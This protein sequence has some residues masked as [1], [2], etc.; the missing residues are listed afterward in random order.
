MGCVALPVWALLGGD[1]DRAA[2]WAPLMAL[3][4]TALGLAFVL[5]DRDRHRVVIEEV[6]H[7]WRRPWMAPPLD[8]MVERPELGDRLVAALTAPLPSEVGLTT[9]LAGAG[10]FG[11][12]RL[13]TWV[14]HRPEIQRRYPGGLLWATVGQEVRGADLAE[15][16][17]DLVFALCGE[18]PNI[19]DPYTAGAELGRVLDE[20]K[21]VLL[22]VDDVW[23]ETQLRPFRFGGRGCTRLVTTRVPHLLPASGVRIAVDAMS[24]DQARRLVADG[25]TELP[26]GAD[27]RL[28]RLAGRWPVLLNLV[29]GVLRQRVARGQTAEHAAA[30]I[31][32][33]LVTDG[34]MAFDPARPADRGWAVAATVEASMI[35]LDAGDRERYLDLAI[36]PEDIDIPVDVLRL[37]WP[38]RGVDGLCDELVGLGLAADY[39]LDQPGPRLVL[40]DVMRAYLRTGRNATEHAAVHLRLL[41]AA[42]GLLPAHDD[43]HDDH[44]GLAWWLLPAEAGYLWRYVPHHLHQADRTD[45]LTRLV[46]D[47]RW[48]EA[49]TCRFGSVVTAEADVEL[50]NTPPAVALRRALR[51]IAPL[52]GPIEPPT[53][54]G[55]TLASR[56]YGVPE[57]QA[58][59]D[60]YRATLFRPRLEPAWPPPDGPDSIRSSRA[61]HAGVVTSCA[62]SPD[63]TLLATASTDGT[64]RLWQVADGSARAVLIGHT[65]GVWDCAFSPNGALLATAGEDRTVRLWQVATGEELD[66][67]TGHTDWVTSCTFSPDGGLLATTSVDETT[68]LWHPADATARAVL[69]GHGNPVRSCAFRPDGTLL[70]TAGEDGTA[71]LWHVATGMEVGVLSGH[72]SAGGIWACAFSPDG[73]LLAT[74]GDDRTARLWHVATGIQRALL[75]GHSSRVNACAFSPDGTTLATAS[76]G[77]V[78]LWHTANATVQTVLTG[79]NAR[80]LGCAFSP[81]G[82]VLATAG[83][84]GIAQLWQIADGSTRAVLTSLDAKVSSCAFSPDGTLL[85]TTG[86]DRIVRLRQVSDGHERQVMIGHSRRVNRCAFSSDG[87]LLATVS[88]DGTTRIWKIPHGAVHAV[89]TGHSGWVRS[90]AFSPDGALLATGGTDGK[91]LLWQVAD[92]TQRA[93]LIGHT[94]RVQSCAFSPDGSLLAT[95]S[96]DRSIRLWQLPDGGTHAVLTGHADGVNDCAFSSDG[97][98]LATASDDRTLRLWRLSDGTARAPLTGHTSWV[99]RCAFSPDG[100]LLAGTSNDGTVRLW[101]VGSGRCHCALRVAAPV[102]GIAWHPAGTLLCTVGGAGVY[103]LTYLP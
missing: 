35:L 24:G 21:A 87:S 67:L 81:D 5:A 65:S 96:S 18:R 23:E 14:C 26:I 52:L 75:T 39:R 73:A 72:A 61:Y 89:L 19:S 40:H 37:L 100:T 11:K 15:R 41:D 102:T 90:C 93:V 64:A 8:R 94:D 20:R 80:V 78:R 91:V 85:A 68:R 103:M 44:A 54:L 1:L 25:V 2:R 36:F 31:I 95:A 6:D 49:K 56:L 42:A 22:V 46:C 55:A 29:N 60:R 84:D 76:Y 33:A 47:L 53:A 88:N 12:T 17:N 70:A 58:P 27:D 30:E 28:A 101:H 66:V 3:P 71:R 59:L 99:G 63:G 50:V 98:L 43:T 92:G 86:D 45:E 4:L 97:A 48:V 77:T 34:P 69:S 79:H 57:L 7:A 13:A 83:I 32:Q 74:A 62:F 9:G 38:G 16:V 10:G 51:Q 82:T